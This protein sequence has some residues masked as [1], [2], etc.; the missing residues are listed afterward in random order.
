[1]NTQIETTPLTHLTLNT[2]HIACTSGI[3][4][5]EELAAVQPLLKHGGPI[6]TRYPYWVELVRAPGCASFAICCGAMPVTLNVLVW[7]D[8]SGPA[9]WAAAERL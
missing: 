4:P 5:P 8:S 9:A 7:E 3:T 1:M 2:G 6:S